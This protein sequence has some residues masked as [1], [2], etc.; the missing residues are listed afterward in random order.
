MTV[1]EFVNTMTWESIKGA[2]IYEEQWSDYFQDYLC[3]FQNKSVETQTDLEPYFDCE[4]DLFEFKGD[5]NSIFIMV[6]NIQNF[7][8]ILK[9]GRP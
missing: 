2:K 5:D 4:L 6:D 3:V 8:L 9:G 7:H 1:K